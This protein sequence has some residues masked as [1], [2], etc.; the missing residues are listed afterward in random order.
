MLKILRLMYNLVATVVVVVLVVLVVVGGRGAGST[1]SI[2]V[3]GSPSHPVRVISFNNSSAL[4]ESCLQ[5]D[6]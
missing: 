5:D 2:R 1:V 3:S 4:A 6:N